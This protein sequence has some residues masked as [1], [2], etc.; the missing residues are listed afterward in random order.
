MGQY[1]GSWRLCQFEGYRSFFGE[2]IWVVITV[3][4]GG[5]LDVL[6]R[7]AATSFSG[8][9]GYRNGDGSVAWP[10][11]MGDTQQQGGGGV[12]GQY[13][14]SPFGP[15]AQQ[16]H[17][18]F[19]SPGGGGGGGG[20]SMATPGDA[21]R[22]LQGRGLASHTFGSSAAAL[23]MMMGQQAQQQ[24]QQQHEEGNEGGGEDTTMG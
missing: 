3:A 12:T 21:F 20:G 15:S 10:V 23:S 7:M 9:L 1:A 4:E 24:Q 2:E 13:P 18:S 22:N 16:Q 17:V 14:P 11:D 5:T 8:G 19:S 6:Q